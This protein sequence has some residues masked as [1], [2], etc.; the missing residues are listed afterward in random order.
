MVEIK[1]ADKEFVENCSPVEVT[2][3]E[4]EDL[5]KDIIPK[6]EE[7]IREIGLGLAGPQI[8]MAKK[9]FIAKDV[10]T[11]EFHTYFNARYIKDNGSRVR[12]EEGCLTYPDEGHHVVKRFKAIKMFYQQLEDGK[13]VDKVKK[14]KGDQAIIFQHECDHIGNGTNQPKTI[15]TR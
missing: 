5:I 13:L 3:E 14:F 8:G 1:L 12:M 6:M 4:A 15:Y 2:T 10:Q 9:F 11:E 7:M